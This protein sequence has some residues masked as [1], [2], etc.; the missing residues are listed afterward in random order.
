[1]AHTNL[2]GGPGVITKRSMPSCSNLPNIWTPDMDRF[3]VRIVML[4]DVEPQASFVRA[5]K[6]RFPELTDV[7]P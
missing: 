3:I 4:N 2:T 1:M 7:S 6:D 5:V